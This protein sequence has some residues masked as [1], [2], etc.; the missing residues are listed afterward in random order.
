MRRYANLDGESGVIGYELHAHAIDVYFRGGHRQGYRY[1][2]LRPG[3][4]HVR[5]MQRLARAG[6][7]LAT[8]INQHVRENYERKL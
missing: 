7:G 2:A 5:Q 6:R 4:E 3:P 8:Y 1:S